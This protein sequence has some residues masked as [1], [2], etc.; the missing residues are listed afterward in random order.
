[1]T[2][3][4]MANECKSDFLTNDHHIS[5]NESYGFLNNIKKN[6]KKS[7]ISYALAGLGL[8]NIACGGNI[9]VTDSVT[10]TPT[11]ITDTA[12]NITGILIENTE[13][14][15]VPCYKLY[16]NQ[17][18]ILTAYV[19]DNGENDVNNGEM[20]F[21]GTA[22]TLNHTT[23]GVG[24]VITPSDNISS[25][26]VHTT[27]ITVYDNALNSDTDSF[28]CKIVMNETQID[29]ALETI[30]QGM[31]N[32][33]EII[34]YRINPVDFMAGGNMYSVDAEVITNAF[35]YVAIDVQGKEWDGDRFSQTKYD[36]ITV[37]GEIY[38]FIGGVTELE[39][40]TQLEELRL[41]GFIH[42][43]RYHDP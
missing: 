42:S 28:E 12:P 33:I 36:Q 2:L 29:L 34:D 39:L 15:R 24:N 23:G 19:D 5:F 31:K 20:N 18:F 38:H 37:P 3:E 16:A 35:R 40:M 26:G 27:D 32:R 43:G 11:P 8:I 7:L 6:A 25:Q 17:S 21:D 10:P 30:L 13:T 14:P 4:K 9:E 1:M 41:D 22:Y